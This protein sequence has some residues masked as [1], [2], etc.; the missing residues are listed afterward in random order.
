MERKYGETVAEVLSQQQKMQEEYDNYVS[1]DEQVAKPA[2]SIS[3]C[4]RSIGSWPA[5]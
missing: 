1:L 5:S 4:W 3:A 2:L